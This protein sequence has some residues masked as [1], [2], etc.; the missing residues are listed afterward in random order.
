MK[1]K[2]GFKLFLGLVLILFLVA[3]TKELEEIN[4]EAQSE[5]FINDSF[6]I[7]SNIEVEEYK[8]D[9]DSIIS[10]TDDG[11]VTGLKKGTATI[12][13]IFTDGRE[14]DHNLEVKEREIIVIY[15]EEKISINESF[16]LTANIKIAEILVNNDVVEVVNKN[17]IK[18]L[19][20][21]VAI[22]TITFVDGRELERIVTVL[23]DIIIEETKSILVGTTFEIKSN[24]SIQDININNDVV[25]ALENNQIRGLKAGVAVIKITFVDE[26]TREIIVTVNNEIIINGKTS[27]YVGEDFKISANQEIKGFSF[28]DSYLSIN[29]E[30]IVKGLKVGNQNIII[31]FIDDQIITYNINILPQIEIITNIKT[32]MIEGDK[33]DIEVNLEVLFFSTNNEYLTVSKEGHVFAKTVGKSI[34][35]LVFIDGREFSYSVNITENLNYEYYHTKVLS[36]DTGKNYMELLDVPVTSYDEDLIVERLIDGKIE[37]GSIEDLYL[38]MENIYVRINQKTQMIEK[39]LI[40]GEVG[41]SN[42]RVGIRQNIGDISD[43]YTLFHD[44]IKFD[45]SSKTL[46][47]TFD[48]VTSQIIPRGKQVEVEAFSG[49]IDVFIDDSLVLSTEK[50]IMFIPEDKSSEM[51]ITSIKRS[52]GNPSYAGNFEISLVKNRLLLINDVSLENYLTKVVPSEMP[53]S[54]HMEALKAQSIAARTYAYADILNRSTSIYGYSVDDSVKSQV[55]NNSSARDRG[56][57]AVYTTSGK[58]MMSGD[59]LV[60]AFYYSTSSGLTG[61]ASEIW[62]DGEVPYLVGQNLTTDDYGN[63]FPVDPTSETAM[64]NF[65][66]TIKLHHPDEAMTMHRWKVKFTKENLAVTLNQFLQSMRNSSP[67]DFLTKSGDDWIKQS[68][69]DNIGQVIDMNVEKR[70]ESGVVMELVFK[71]T[72]GTYKIINQ[73]NIRFTVRPRTAGATMYYARSTDSGFNNKLNNDTTLPSGFFAI[74]KINNEF[75]VYGGGYGHGVGMSQ[76]GANYLGKNGNSFQEILETYYSNVTIVDK[77]YNYEPID[78]F[79]DYLN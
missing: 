9:E 64:L 8:T 59:S 25:E 30:N 58:I 36:F 55:Y 61:S 62:F 34:L 69:P 42:I 76:N 74:E 49:R 13:I 51:K 66:K 24:V 23:Q 4:I 77:S 40:E 6:T 68:I 71:T 26:R 37:Y 52:Q 54:Y 20:A 11:L 12:T 31:T 63:I 7:V 16:Q 39:F 17:T 2:N 46:L 47:K 22:L 3:C 73:Y 18:G 21:G 27:I 15:G 56:N 72:T 43:E 79:Q 75:V 60:Q 44:L 48:N 1:M 78:N 38:G 57:E 53:T 10:I 28:D 5:I 35:T 67:K 29:D 32:E 33:Y 14:K 41:F 45:T 19:K 65:F 50:R 70:G